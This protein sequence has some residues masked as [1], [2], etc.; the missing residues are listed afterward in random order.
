MPKDDKCPRCGG[1]ILPGKLLVTGRIAFLPTNQPK[2]GD[3]SISAAACQKC[4]HIELTADI[5][6]LSAAPA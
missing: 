5:S 3:A 6:K 4:G 2:S 1:E